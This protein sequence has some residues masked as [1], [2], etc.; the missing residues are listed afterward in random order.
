[1]RSIF[2]NCMTHPG[3]RKSDGGGSGVASLAK[4]M[5]EMGLTTGPTQRILI[6]KIYGSPTTTRHR[7]DR[8]ARSA[9]PLPPGSRTDAW[10]RNRRVSSRRLGRVACGGGV[11]VSGAP[12]ARI[13]GCDRV[14][15]GYFRKQPE[16]SLLQ[17]HAARA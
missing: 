16:G 15:V 13:T 1:D 11:T 9:H 17:A 4:S 2:F 8:D 12:P 7:R 14:H 10:I 6:S 5:I 3:A